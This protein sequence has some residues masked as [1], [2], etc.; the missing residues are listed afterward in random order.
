MDSE[1]T[2]EDR[3]AAF[4]EVLERAREYFDSFDENDEGDERILFSITMFPELP[5]GVGDVS[6]NR[7]ALR[8]LMR[9]VGQA[10]ESI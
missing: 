4:S 8:F 7:E 10:Q 3:L 2:F 9:L 6:I 1:T 5:T